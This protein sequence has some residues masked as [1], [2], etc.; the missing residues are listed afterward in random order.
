M[1]RFL[2]HLILFAAPSLALGQ[3]FDAYAY[4]AA[5]T[6]VCLKNKEG[7]DD[8]KAMKLHTYEALLAYCEKESNGIRKNKA[9][10]KAIHA[11]STDTLAAYL[12]L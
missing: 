4:M 1:R 7:A 3:R 5:A 6:K 9:L 12:K 2:T 11:K 10:Q 8:A